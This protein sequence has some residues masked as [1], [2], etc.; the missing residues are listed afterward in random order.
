MRTV[1]IA[2][3]AAMLIGT[4]CA[5]SSSN[6]AA[7]K[8]EDD[9][10]TANTRHAVIAARQALQDD[11]NDNDRFALACLIEAVAALDERM[12]GLADGSVPFG[13]PIYAPKGVVMIKPS[14]QEGR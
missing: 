9:A 4:C 5:S 1:I 10:C 3:A 12:Q 6:A 11:R 14:G 7:K 13:G 8:S 2:T